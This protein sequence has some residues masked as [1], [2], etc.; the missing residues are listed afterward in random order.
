MA[1]HASRVALPEGLPYFFMS[2]DMTGYQI[3]QESCQQVNTLAPGATRA[4]PTATAHRLSTA[5][6]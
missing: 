1:P 5:L 2:D 6:G 4:T 3:V